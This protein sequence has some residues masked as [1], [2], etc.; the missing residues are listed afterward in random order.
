MTVFA[1]D[2]CAAEYLEHE[3]AKRTFDE[4]ALFTD[5]L[6]RLALHFASQTVHNPF[7]RPMFAPL[8]S[9]PAGYLAATSTALGSFLGSPSVN[10]RTDDDK[11]LVL[12]TRRINAPLNLL[13][14]LKQQAIANEVTTG[15]AEEEPLS[16]NG[17]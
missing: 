17:N 8:R 15:S 11:T 12:A 16:N 10:D 6:Q 9:A 5:G 4:L 3:I 2:P 7:F 1:T 14:P 13:D